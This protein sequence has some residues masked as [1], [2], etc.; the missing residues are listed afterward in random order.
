MAEVDDEVERL[1][2]ENK[3]L[4]ERVKFLA[5]KEKETA[6]YARE[7][8]KKFHHILPQVSCNTYLK[9]ILLD[10][11]KYDD[12]AKP[13]LRINH[14]RV[15]FESRNDKIAKLA[16][17][18]CSKERLPYFRDNLVEADE[19]YDWLNPDAS[20]YSEDMSKKDRDNFRKDLYQW[21]R[22]LN[23]KISPYIDNVKLFETVGSGYRLS[24]RVRLVSGVKKIS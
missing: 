24:R 14:F 15:R 8:S 21:F 7:F 10:A 20:W 4:E 6:D 17:A 13:T 22:R 11:L 2:A 1:K 9:I 5:K 18:V 16:R 12:D 19:I 3:R 23:E